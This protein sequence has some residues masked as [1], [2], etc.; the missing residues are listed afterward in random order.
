M[1]ATI[2]ATMYRSPARYVSDGR[3]RPEGEVQYKHTISI[4]GAAAGFYCDADLTHQL[5]GERQDLDQGEAVPVLA[6]VDL[7]V[8]AKG[9]LIAGDLVALASAE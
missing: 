5:N 9:K 1:H 8:N 7:Y 2:N 6:T 3:F 4:E